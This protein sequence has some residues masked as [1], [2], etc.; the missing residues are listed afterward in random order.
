M[1]TPFEGMTAR[2]VVCTVH[3]LSSL[4]RVPSPALVY[5]DPFPPQGTRTPEIIFLLVEGQQGA[6]IEKGNSYSNLATQ[7][8]GGT[9][10]H[11]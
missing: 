11:G 4:C 7:R 2:T 10:K 6:R 8:S 9:F 3:G 5:L 1:C